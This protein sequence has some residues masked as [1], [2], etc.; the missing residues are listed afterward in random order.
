MTKSASATPAR[1][2]LAVRT[3]KMEG[4]WKKAKQ[5]KHEAEQGLE[6]SAQ[7]TQL[8]N[9]TDT[10]SPLPKHFCHLYLIV[11][12]RFGTLWESTQHHNSMLYMGGQETGLDGSSF[13][14]L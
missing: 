10:A 11:W 9:L 8:V 4:S 2:V 7:V 3:V 6:L 12:M 1:V 5:K 13:E 14:Q